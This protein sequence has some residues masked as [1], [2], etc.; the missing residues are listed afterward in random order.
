M[1]CMKIGIGDG[2]TC[3]ENGIDASFL[4]AGR[5][6]ERLQGKFLNVVRARKMASVVEYRMRMIGKIQN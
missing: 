5:A 3:K 1:D 6:I 2:A 4:T